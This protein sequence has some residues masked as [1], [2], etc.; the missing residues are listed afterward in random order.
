MITKDL[1][2]TDFSD[3]V[4]QSMFKRYFA[5]IDVKVNDWES[6]WEEMN[7]QNGGNTAYIRTCDNEP[8]GFIQFTEATL[9]NWFLKERLGF[10]REFWV[11]EKFRKQGH[12]TEL[13]YLAEKYFKDNGIRRVVLTAEEN[14]QQFYLNRRYMI[15]ENIKAKNGMAVSVKDI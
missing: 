15:C 14:E 2:I 3:P 9:E 1:L 4:F 8:V 13:L 10:I 12:G 7:T 11:A 6:L 5:E